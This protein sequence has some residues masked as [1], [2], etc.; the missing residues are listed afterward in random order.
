MGIDRYLFICRKSLY[1]SLDAFLTTVRGSMTKNRQQIRME[2]EVRRL[3][4]LLRQKEE[5]LEAQRQLCNGT[6]HERLHCQH[7]AVIVARQSLTTTSAQCMEIGRSVVAAA[8][9]AGD[10]RWDGVELAAVAVGGDCLTWRGPC[11]VRRLTEEGTEGLGLKFKQ[12]KGEIAA[13]K[14]LRD[15]IRRGV[16][17]LADSKEMVGEVKVVARET[18]VVV[19]SAT[20]SLCSAEEI[21]TEKGGGPPKAICDAVDGEPTEAIRDGEAGPVTKTTPPTITEKEEGNQGM[22]V[23]ESKLGEASDGGEQPGTTIKTTVPEYKSP[24]EHMEFLE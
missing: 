11:L 3:R 23:E 19:A 22:A 20:K 5:L 1:Q 4:K 12:Y 13:Y 8:G 24:L 14:D 9:E 15:K 6:L 2:L 21:T 7:K 18:A 10:F 17:T 16:F